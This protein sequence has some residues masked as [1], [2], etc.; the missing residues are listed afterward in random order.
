M[1]K[2]QFIEQ[3]ENLPTDAITND[4]S[5]PELTPPDEN[6]WQGFVWRTLKCDGIDVTYQN[7]YSRPEFPSDYDEVAFSDDVPELWLRD[8]LPTVTDDDGDE[9]DW[10]SICELILEHTSIGDF[11]VQFPEIENEDV[12]TDINT[13]EDETTTD[14]CNLL[15]RV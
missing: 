9:L 4:Y 14:L 7:Y 1:N 3:L 8:E 10:H 15:A 13:Q 12:D 5:T 2:T 6:I 11:E